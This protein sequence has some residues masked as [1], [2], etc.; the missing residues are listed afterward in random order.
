MPDSG[1]VEVLQK[2]QAL[3]LEIPILMLSGVTDLRTVVESMKFGALD[4]LI[5]PFEEETLDRIL[6]EV[7]VRA[8][9]ANPAH[10]RE[11]LTDN[12]SVL[13]QAGIVAKVAHTDVPIL[14]LGESGVGKE[15]MA[16]FAHRQ[17][18]RQDKPF[19]KI[20]PRG[21]AS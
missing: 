20:N 4:F 19:V 1:R 21:A 8:P 11:F 15:V 2:V 7:F 5:K 9:A 16:R 13:R 18:A 17:S 10:R 12:P 3:G 6:D 14:I